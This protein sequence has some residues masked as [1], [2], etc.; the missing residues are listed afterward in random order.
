MNPD[1]EMPPIRRSQFLK[2]VPGLRI[3]LQRLGDVRRQMR[4]RWLWRIGIIRRRCRE[5]RRRQQALGLEL[6]PALAIDIRPVAARLARRELARIAFIVEALDEAVD[7]SE[8]QRFAHRI[9]IRYRLAS[10][11][12]L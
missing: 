5:A 3:L 11:V 10:G 6:Q 7:P 4:N 2:E 1:N 9:L 12:L 8:A